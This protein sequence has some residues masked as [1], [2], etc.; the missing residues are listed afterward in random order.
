MIRFI[1][2]VGLP[3]LSYWLA[4]SDLPWSFIPA[5]VSLLL[6]ALVDIFPARRLAFHRALS[7]FILFNLVFWPILGFVLVSGLTS[8]LVSK[9]LFKDYAPLLSLNLFFCG[10][11]FALQQSAHSLYFKKS[12]LKGGQSEKVLVD[13]S[14]IIDGRILPLCE[15]GFIPKN[16][17]IPGFVVRELQLI[18]DS[19]SQEKRFKGRR[20]L[21]LLQQMKGSDMVSVEIPDTDYQDVRGVDN[22]LLKMAKADE[23]S[24]LTTD[25]NLQKV[26][27]VED[28]KI[29]NVNKLISM[30]KPNY[31][32]GDKINVRLVK[33]GNS[34]RQAVGYLED[35]TMVVMEDGDRFINQTKKAVVTSYVQS[36]TGKMVFCKPVKR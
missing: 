9:P 16:L 13:T 33:K 18:A 34:K 7:F 31:A 11:Y 10:L 2:Y 12:S 19:A 15:S 3:A 1:F 27:Q 25:F 14:A 8:D 21:E 36:E 30:L 32:P 4:P 20:G 24:I 5:G 22:K 23:A 28:L 6:F 29:L 17:T 35:D 26:A